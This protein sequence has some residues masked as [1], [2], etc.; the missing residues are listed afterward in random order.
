LHGLPAAGMWGV[1]IK[2]NLR[3]EKKLLQNCTKAAIVL[4]LKRF[5]DYFL[6]LLGYVLKVNII[7]FYFHFEA[8]RGVYMAYNFHFLFALQQIK[9]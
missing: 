3:E 4:S 5:V 2:V 7:P 6:P 9:V 1:F 8:K